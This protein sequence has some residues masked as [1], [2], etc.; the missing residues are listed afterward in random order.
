M[1]AGIPRE[2]TKMN[3]MQ[4]YLSIGIPTFMVLVGIVL[5]S[6]GSDSIRK[7]VAALRSDT[8]TRLTNIEGDLRRFYQIMG[9]NTGKI[10]ILS[11]KSS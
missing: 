1:F 5:S 3:N 4:L 10:E 6:R 2:K 9:E 11:R 7:E 8:N